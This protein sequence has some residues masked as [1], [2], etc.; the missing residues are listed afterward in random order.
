M[1]HIRCPLIKKD[2]SKRSLIEHTVDI[3]S[4][5]Y[6]LSRTFIISSFFFVP[7]STLSNCSYKF[8]R[9]LEHCFLKLSLCTTIFLIPTA[10]FR[11]VFHPLSQTFSFH[12]FECWKNTFDGIFI[13]SYF[14]TETCQYVVTLM[15][16]TR[17][18]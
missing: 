14:N 7:F 2:V 5:V 18:R 4:L 10:L 17:K 12:S 8:V 15:A 16:L 3:R 9:Y 1:F 6:L 13:F 11:A